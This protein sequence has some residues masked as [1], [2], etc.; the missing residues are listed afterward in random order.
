MDTTHGQGNIKVR[1]EVLKIEESPNCYPSE[2]IALLL[3]LCTYHC[4]TIKF[5]FGHYLAVLEEIQN[6]GKYDGFPV[7]SEVKVLG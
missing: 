7:E 6:K 3:L 4:T 2:T 1:A 5:S